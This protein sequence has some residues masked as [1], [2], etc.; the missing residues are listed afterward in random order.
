MTEVAT[1]R[2]MSRA[3]RTSSSLSR[4]ATACFLFL[5]PQ[6]AIPAG[7]TYRPPAASLFLLVWALLALVRPRALRISSAD[8]DALLRLLSCFFLYC[9]VSAVYGYCSL[10]SESRLTLRL[11]TGNV[12]YVRVAAE[13]LLQL[14]LVIVA[15]EVVRRSRSTPRQ[16][17][18]WWLNGMAAAVAL[19]V[20]TYLIT[21]DPLLQRAGTFNEGNL[22]GLYYLTSVF[23][24]LEYRRTSRAGKGS[25]FLVLAVLGVLLSRSTAGIVLLS[26]LFATRY[27]LAARDGW[28]RT[29]R[30]L[31]MF[32]V[33]PVAGISISSA[34][35]D[36]GIS[37]KLFEQDVTA[38]SFSRIDRLESIA[39]AI[40]LFVESPVI[41]NG[42]QTY[43]FLSNDLLDGPLLAMYD[44]SYR[45]IP[46]NIYAEIAAELGIVGLAIFGAFLASLLRRIVRQRRDIDRNLLF[47]IIAI[48]LYWN[49]YP[50]YSVVFVWAFF[51]L[52]MASLRVESISRTHSC[53]SS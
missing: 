26:I 21:D 35:L 22:A 28:S 49:A 23:V 18:C 1:V 4:H 25:M 43:G 20:L 13:R 51:G 34:G 52:A 36:F 15:F 48:L 29:R 38:N 32:I 2:S 53:T 8:P 45:R 3:P 16:L 14:L 33:L 5:L 41:G 11:T 17:M 47:G 9:L 39:A 27:T 42:L 44:G 30:T 31:L 46:N 24:G 19:H 37:E 7:A 10:A 40:R 6:F 12:D 50:T